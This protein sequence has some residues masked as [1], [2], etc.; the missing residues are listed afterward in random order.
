MKY[1]SSVN[2]FQSKHSSDLDITIII[3]DKDLNHYDLLDDIMQAVMEHEQSKFQY[4]EPTRYKIKQNMPSLIKSGYLLKLV[5]LYYNV[6]ID[7]MVN[8]ISEI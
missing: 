8:R 5:D 7:I 2:G 3:D 6:D 4:F 1:G